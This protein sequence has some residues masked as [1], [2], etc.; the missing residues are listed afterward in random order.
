MAE[1]LQEQ[2][3]VYFANAGST[4]EL[5]SNMR[6][7]NTPV[8][9]L[10]YLG[11]I[12]L[13]ACVFYIGAAGAGSRTVTEVQGALNAFSLTVLGTTELL[14]ALI[15][16]AVVCTAVVGEYQRKSID[17]VFSAPVTTKYYLVGKLIGA[18]RY[19]ALLVFMTLPVI[20]LGVVLGGVTPRWVM[21]TLFLCSMHG[22]LFAA[23]SLPIATV[24]GRVV[25][26]VGYSLAA[27]MAVAIQPVLLQLP[28]A[29]PG[30]QPTF[31][32]AMTPFL[33]FPAADSATLVGGTP[34]PNW[35]LGSAALLLIVR[36]FV[37]GSTACSSRP[38]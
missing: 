12:T 19:V 1:W 11:F 35:I 9:L 4:R 10:C 33:L 5:R 14:V 8:T 2:Y 22:L 28:A 36:V 32:S 34:V 17:L 15:A 18:A 13:L 26:A 27:C 20:A 25:P 16:P 24:S 37:G 6:G 29:G 38:W 21:T 31:L 23:V 3:R 30:G 7:W